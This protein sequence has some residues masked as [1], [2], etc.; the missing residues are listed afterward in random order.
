[1]VKKKIGTF[2]YITNNGEINSRNKSL[3]I[4]HE[5]NFDYYFTMDSNILFSDIMLF[6]KLIKRDRGIVS[7]LIDNKGSWRNFWGDLDPNGWYKRSDD[8]FDIAYR[9]ITGLWNVPYITNSFMIQKKYV[10][11]LQNCFIYGE[12]DSDMAFCRHCRDKGIFMYIDN[13]DKYGKFINVK[14]ERFNVSLEE[15][16]VTE[17]TNEVIKPKDKNKQKIV[18]MDDTQK[19]E[20]KQALKLMKN[21]GMI[22]E[23][24]K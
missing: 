14:D 11:Q 9:E 4:S 16:K 7:P 23:E 24:E 12:D 2:S 5:A 1:M 8:Y 10:E 17:H 15:T 3:E 6:Q 21:M 22:K 13:V 20:I 18:T 19:R